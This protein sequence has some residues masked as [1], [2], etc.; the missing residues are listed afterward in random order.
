MSVLGTIGAVGALGGAAIG[1]VGANAAAGKQSSA[2]VQAA[3]IQAQEAQNALD[4]QKQ[5]YAQNQQ[6]IAPWLQAGQ[7]AVT[8]LSQLAGG[9]QPWTSTFQAP[10]AAQAAATPGYQFELGQGLQA[11]QNSAAASGGLLSGGTQKGL[12][13]YAE[14]LASTDYANTYNRALGEYQ[15]A[16]NIFQQNQAIPFNRYAA[17]AGLGQTAAGQLASSGQSAANNVGNISLTSGAQ[18]GAALQN[19]GAAT[20]SGYV[21]VA[22]ALSGGLTGA[23]NNLSQYYLLSQLLGGQGGIPNGPGVPSYTDLFYPGTPPIV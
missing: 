18:Q 10:T 3:N 12:A 15:Q 1:A 20:A 14:G 17:V 16:Y 4:F 21:G 5:V 9:Y 19:A 2:A 23:T 13:N 22:N 6:N 8:Q 11:I 7:G